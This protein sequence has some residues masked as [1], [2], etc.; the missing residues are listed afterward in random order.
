MRAF[1]ISDINQD[2][3]SYRHHTDSYILKENY[4]ANF[5]EVFKLSYIEDI[6]NIMLDRLHSLDKIK[7]IAGANKMLEI[8][9]RETNYATAFATGS[10][11]KPAM[12]KL[13]QTGIDFH[14]ELLVSSNRYYQREQIVKAAIENAKAYYQVDAFEH[15]I[16]IGDGIWDLKTAQNLGL[17]F[18][19]IGLENAADFKAAGIPLYIEDWKS[20]ELAKMEQSLGI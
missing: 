9:Q 13:E 8:L 15:I 6:E 7:C 12:F 10:L 3:K 5:H 18:V 4:E 17:H 14:P 11:L 2:W 16:S 20:F 19:G 1:G